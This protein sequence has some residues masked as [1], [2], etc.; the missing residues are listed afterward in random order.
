MRFVVLSIVAVI[1]SGVFG[2]FAATQLF[3]SATAA[4]PPPSPQPVAVTSPLDAQGNVKV[5]EQGTANVSVTNANLPVSGTVNVGNLPATQDV[6]VVS[7]PASSSPSGRLIELGTQSVEG[8]G[9][10]QTRFADVS[11]C[12]RVTLMARSSSGYPIGISI[13]RMS[14]DGVVAVAA[15]PAGGQPAGTAGTYSIHDLEIVMP[16]VRL[17]VSNGNSAVATE[18]T[19]WIWCQP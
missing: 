16:F 19:A 11:D 15:N 18:I 6:N 13:D 1:V 5:H 3:G 2:A 9:L 8:G 12:R 17:S 10:F 4:P 14:P 7:M